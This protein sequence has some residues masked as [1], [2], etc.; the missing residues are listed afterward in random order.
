MDAAAA[1]AAAPYT[2]SETSG[3]TS[4]LFDEHKDTNTD[5]LSGLLGLF[6]DNTGVTKNFQVV[7]NE[8]C[9]HLCETEI[10]TTVV[11]HKN[12]ALAEQTGTLHG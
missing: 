8:A 3:W 4:S 11:Q 10:I 12:S 6:H 1:A 9:A 2:H 7:I 5:R